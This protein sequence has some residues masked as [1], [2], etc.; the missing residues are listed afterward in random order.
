M[1]L[2]NLRNE[3]T[4]SGLRHSEL[5]DDPYT[6]FEHWLEQANNAGLYQP[7]A[8]TLA[9]V[10]AQG[11][12]SARTVLLK[13]VDTEGFVFYTNYG[14]RKARE[15]DA[16]PRVALLF[17]WLDL[18]RQIK[19]RGSARRVGMAESLRYFLTR[20]R[21]SQLGAWC[22]QQSSVISSRSLLEE[23]FER[24]KRKFQHQEV[25][26][27]SF[28]GGYRVVPEEIEF[29]QGRVNRLHDRFQ[30]SRDGQGGWAVERLA[31]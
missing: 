10:S 28:W 29:W 4:R 26:L 8:M 27:P 14:S 23:E 12:P 16:H 17:V 25:P 19:I 30:Y 21:G 15:I 18:E 7:N 5:A 22:S 6:Q 20:P 11:Q 9:T 31:P 13:S 24:M 3:Y 1:D 2:G